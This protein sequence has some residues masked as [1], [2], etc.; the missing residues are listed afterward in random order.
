MTYHLLPEW[1]KQDAIVI[2]WP[3]QY[4]GWKHILADAEDC[5]FHMAAA[6]TQHQ[7]LLIIC[8]NQAHQ[9]KI[10]KRLTHLSQQNLSFINI[11]TNDTWIRDYGPLTV[12]KN[13][14]LLWLD[15]TFNAWGNKFGSHLDNIVNQ[16]L[17]QHDWF[18]DYYKI[19]TVPYTLEG[20]AVE[21]NGA[22]YFFS[23][24]SVIDNPN[25]HNTAHINSI[26]KN[27]FDCSEVNILQNGHLAGD[28]T[29]GHIDTLVRFFNENSVIY[30]E[31]R[32]KND[33]HFEPLSNM[34][35]ELKKTP[36][37]LV[38]LPIPEARYDAYGE[39]LPGTYANFLIGN[40]AVYVPIYKCVQD[41]EALDILKQCFKGY[42]VIGI[43]CNVLII[44]RG[45]LHCSTMQIPARP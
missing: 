36:F 5:F 41:A 30:C 43:D 1:Q 27:Y 24:T 31:C 11:Q 7:R 38:A 40:G 32:D 39:R 23:T 22:G 10:K 3:H 21:V 8:Y 19:H 12:K 26:A 14:N 28:D 9:D 2:T 20:G 29:D 18:R 6:I 33:E 45:S 25:R 13:N 34:H 17:I 35:E 37:N 44:Q 16:A 42:E 4:S 15:F